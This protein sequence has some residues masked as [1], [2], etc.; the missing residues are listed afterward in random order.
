MN[1]IVSLTSV[2]SAVQGRSQEF[3]KKGS[4]GIMRTHLTMINPAR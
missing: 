2:G 3:T 4:R 1:D